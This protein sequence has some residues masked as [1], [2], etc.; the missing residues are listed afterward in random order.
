[1][2]ATMRRA[3]R[4]TRTRL[5]LMLAAAAW[6]LLPAAHAEMSEIHVAQQYGISYLPLMIMEDRK[7]I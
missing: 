7:L 5:T 6:A 2:A 3:L 1:M 4:G